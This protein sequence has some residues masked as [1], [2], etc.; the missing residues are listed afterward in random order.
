[1]LDTDVNNYL[2]DDLLVKMDVATMAYSLE[3]RSPFLDHKVMEFMARVPAALKLRDGKTKYLLKSALRGVLP[4]AILD[5]PK[6]GFGVP[7]GE[8][9]RSSLKELMLD[10]VLSDR[11][12]ARGY[13]RPA[14]LREMVDSQ[15]AGS[16][17]FKYL[18]WDLLLLER[19]H[20]IFIDQEP[21]PRA[22][23]LVQARAN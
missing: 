7:L 20:R 4:D 14:A 11:A 13:F 19:W 22:P 15:L 5:R 1:M 21:L 8:W 6:M 18:L 10:S 2:P 9:L 16:D 23:V 3:A 12:L 17:R